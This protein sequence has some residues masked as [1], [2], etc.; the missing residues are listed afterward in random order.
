[1]KAP[2]IIAMLCLGPLAVIAAPPSDAYRLLYQDNFD[3][4]SVNETDWV[5]RIERRG[6]EANFSGINA[7]NRKENVSV[8]GGMLRVRVEQETIDGKKENTGGGVITKKRFGY[9]YYECR[10]KPFMKG[11]G[12]VHSAFWQRGPTPVALG[13]QLL[14]PSTPKENVLFEIDSSELDNPH[15]VSTNNLYD[16]IATKAMKD[17]YPWPARFHIPLKPLDGGWFLDAYEYTPQGVIFYD[18]GKEVARID[19]NRIRGQQN[20]WLTC[21]NGFGAKIDASVFPGEAEFD[22]FRFYARD[23]PGANLLA[24]EGFEYNLDRIDLQDPVAWLERGDSEA[25]RVLAAGNGCVLRHESA[26]PYQVTTSQTLQYI[27]NGI[28]HAS[29]KVRSSGGQRVARMIV[30]ETGGE[31]LLAEIPAGTAWQTITLQGI[32]VKNHEAKVA[33][34]SDADASQW[35]EVDD[36]CFFKPAAPDQQTLE[37]PPFRAVL[38]PIWQI[39]PEKP[40]TFGDGRFCF[41]GR[42]VGSGEAITVKFTMRPEKR[43]NQVALERFPAK[44]G[45]AGWSVRLTSKGDVA[46][47]IGTKDAFQEV[48]AR[49]AYQA[50]RETQVVCTVDHG[51]ATVFID[52]R[53]AATLDDLREAPLDLTAAGSV[54]GHR[55]SVKEPYRGELRD[56]RVFNHALQ[57]SQIPERQTP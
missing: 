45:P 20:V 30:S 6:G 19:Y 40:M 56:I 49:N 31:S 10:Y 52:G 32:E 54:G 1:M 7:L 4:K 46:F 13:G 35:L 21:L 50:G 36:V 24:N 12:G 3:G 34:T 41:F 42:E 5:Y 22:Y 2:S 23:F 9:G 14:D 47:R 17:G 28:H 37:S 29:A 11:K 16:I 38:D 27:P 53:A 25:S 33:F 51:K 44:P 48:L 39:L 26:K 18:N 8:S 55:T 43:S 57:P 15:W